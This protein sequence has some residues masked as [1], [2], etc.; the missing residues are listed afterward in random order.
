MMKWLSHSFTAQT[1]GK[2]GPAHRGVA[3][4]TLQGLQSLLG[5]RRRGTASGGLVFPLSPG[6]QLL[7]DG[8]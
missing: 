2:A 7:L 1:W 4:L 6:S 8:E 3:A 5:T